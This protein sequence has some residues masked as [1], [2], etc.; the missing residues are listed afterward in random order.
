LD[1]IYG[2]D[3]QQ[4]MLKAAMKRAEQLVREYAPVIKQVA[5]EL[6]VD[7][8]VYGTR[9]RELIDEFNSK[10][11]DVSVIPT[12]VDTYPEKK[13]HE[14]TL[15]KPEP[16][17]KEGTKTR[18]KKEGEGEPNLFDL[19]IGA[20]HWL[21]A[22]T[23]GFYEKEEN[24]DSAFDENR[25]FVT[26]FE[27]PENNYR[28]NW[29]AFEI[30]HQLYTIPTIKEVD[31]FW[32][33][34][35]K[36]IHDDW[37]DEWLPKWLQLRPE[38]YGG[39]GK[40]LECYRQ[41]QRDRIAN[42]G[43]K[44]G[45]DVV[46]QKYLAGEY[47]KDW[48]GLSEKEQTRKKE[49]EAVGVKTDEKPFGSWQ[50]FDDDGDARQRPLYA[51]PGTGRLNDPKDVGPVDGYTYVPSTLS[52]STATVAAPKPA[53]TMKSTS[54]DTTT[55]NGDFIKNAWQSQLGSSQVSSQKGD[56]RSPLGSSVTEPSVSE[57][58]SSA[59]KKQ[60]FDCTKIDRV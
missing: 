26:T 16:W 25:D 48:R 30:K 36:G 40:P 20:R 1:K 23:G 57:D 58:V 60:G 59:W 9:I 44:E 22:A 38:R 12:L 7:D 49:I 46:I 45:F 43:G 13:V 4:L 42:G 41:M 35:V 56:S 50:P 29:T 14:V 52:S 34:E 3:D 39:V 53:Q 11:D 51:A 33:D 54:S 37:P 8:R 5:S 18:T 15:E 21:N 28:Q 31:A 19:E 27:T 32:K 24:V 55:S 47:D 17:V 10:R 2:K 6:L